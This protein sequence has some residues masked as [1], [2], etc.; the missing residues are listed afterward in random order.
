MK[1]CRRTR[2]VAK[3]APASISGA[4]AI[5]STTAFI[6]GEEKERGRGGGHRPDGLCSVRRG[7]PRP[8]DT[9]WGR[10]KPMQFLRE[11]ATASDGHRYTLVTELPPEQHTL[12][13][14]HGIPGLGILIA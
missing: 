12:F 4:S 10:L 9:F 3:M 14:P 13:G 11:S 8:A 6:F 1:R 5:H 7:A 2:P